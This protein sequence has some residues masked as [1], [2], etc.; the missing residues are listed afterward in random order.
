[1]LFGVSP[2]N[3]WSSANG[4][5]LEPADKLAIGLLQPDDFIAK[6]DTLTLQ[7]AIGNELDKLNQDTLKSLA[8]ISLKKAQL[9]NNQLGKL[10]NY[11]SRDYLRNLAQ[12]VFFRTR[13]INWQKNS[14]IS[15]LKNVWLIFKINCAALWPRMQY[16]TPV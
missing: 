14:T 15:Y 12:F 9:Y 4:P 1:M 2:E 7:E 11:N 16:A 5:Y 3:I 6:A 8:D 10:T 13:G